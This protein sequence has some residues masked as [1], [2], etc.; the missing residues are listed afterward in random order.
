MLSKKCKILK[1]SNEDPQ[2]EAAENILAL[3]RGIDAPDSAAIIDDATSP[4]NPEN[5]PN[6]FHPA[7]MFVDN[8]DGERDSDDDDAYYDL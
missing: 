5:P 6:A 4:S 2:L 1:Q 3:H 8:I 7:T